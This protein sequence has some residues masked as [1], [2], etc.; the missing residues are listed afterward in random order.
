MHFL[1]S[2]LNLKHADLVEKMG[3]LVVVRSDFVEKSVNSDRYVV[4]F[5][6]LCHYVA[7]RLFCH[8]ALHNVEKTHA[9][10]YKINRKK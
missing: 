1:E 7:H 2:E 6:V 9:N 3:I 8:Y 5:A 10:L 4:Q